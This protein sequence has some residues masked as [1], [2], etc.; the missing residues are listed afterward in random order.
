[1]KYEFNEKGLLESQSQI[2][3][4]KDHEDCQNEAIKNDPQL[5]KTLVLMRGSSI[6]G[7]QYGKNEKEG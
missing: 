6:E 7:N 3:T 4:N 5:T 1:M 2:I